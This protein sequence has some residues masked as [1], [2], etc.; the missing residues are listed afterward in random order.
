MQLVRALGR[1]QDARST[2]V[3][4]LETGIDLR[5]SLASFSSVSDC[6]TFSGATREVTLRDSGPLQI[7]QAYRSSRAVFPPG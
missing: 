1:F 4:E 3:N 6:I 7:S 5:N 2:L